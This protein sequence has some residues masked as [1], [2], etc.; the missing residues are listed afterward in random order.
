MELLP[1]A[2]MDGL[3]LGGIYITVAIAF[4]LAYGVMH[5]IDFAVGEWIML[6]A[7]A[8]YYFN[9]WSHIDPFLLLPAV[10]VVFT[11]VGF[12]L[13]P[14]L[15]R[16]LS[17]RQ[18]NP[19]LM[20]LVFTF[21]LA[22]MIRGLA[23]TVFGFYTHSIPSVFSEGSIFVQRGNFFLTISSVRLAALIYALI[24]TVLLHFLL[25]KTT[26]GLGVRALAQNRDAA[27][28]MGVNGKRTNSWVYGLYVGISAM[29]GVLIGCILSASAQMGPQYTVIAFFVV[30]LAGMGYLAGVPWAAFLLG[31]VQSFFLIYLNPSYTMLAVF[32][33]LFAILL[34][35]PKGLFGR[36]I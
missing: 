12:L 1:Q 8:G 4:S 19:L 6:G 14:V 34:I 23:L 25:K 20:G 31:M 2:L 32:A 11:L 16:V 35:S 22:L 3:L 24:I 15:H 21:G 30:V 26:F 18:G 29:T 5:I 10:F 36:G 28:L 9:L 7:F 33:I 13:Q 17:G 27:A